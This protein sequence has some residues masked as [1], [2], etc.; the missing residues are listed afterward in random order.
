MTVLP[1][2]GIGVDLCKIERMRRFIGKE[3]F[4]ARV[5]SEEERDYALARS[6][7][8]RHLAGAF[9]AR[10]ALAK[11]GGW[12]LAKIGLKS[13]SVRHVDG[14]PFLSVG[15]DLRL[16]FDEAGVERAHLSLSHDGDYA[17][18]VVLLEGREPAR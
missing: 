15:P 9:A 16:L 3:A 6:D 1:V 4:L 12:G 17:V 11:A 5:F 7:P 2:R 14:R 10:E 13:L 18:A 8:A